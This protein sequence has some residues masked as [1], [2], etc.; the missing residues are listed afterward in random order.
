[1]K[2][3]K[4]PLKVFLGV[5]AFVVAMGICFGC[6]ALY[7]KKEIAK[8]R[9]NMPVFDPLPSATP[10]PTDKGT[11]ASYVDSLYSKLLGADDA[12]VSHS[13]GIRI[14]LDLDA[15]TFDEA[16]KDVLGLLKD[17][18]ASRISEMYESVS[19]TRVDS[20][21]ILPD[22][23]FEIADVTDAGAE[24]GRTNEKGE[25]FDD[26]YYYVTMSLDPSSRDAAAVLGSDVYADVMTQFG[27]AA[28]ISGVSAEIAG[29]DLSFKI[30][31]VGDKLLS[32]TVATRYVFTA[33]AAFKGDYVDLGSQRIGA[34]VTKTESFLFKW[35]GL[36][37]TD[38]AVAVKP[39]TL[40]TLPLEICV[41]DGATPDEW[42]LVAEISDPE[43]LE[44]E[45]V[46]AMTTLKVSEDPVTIKMT[47]RYDGHEYSDTITVFVTDLEVD[48]D[49]QTGEGE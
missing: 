21:D 15:T 4:K 23:L 49:W 11:I 3:M 8:G 20:T 19:W 1:M 48:Y 45:G 47:L 32:A 5:V 40:S 36:R 39:G 44:I 37:F 46:G 24:R 42:E 26:D 16:D 10:L 41:D 22:M 27:S 25:I 17:S 13:V 7:A 35:Y 28:D 18:W 2:K 34:G 6:L 14:D 38:R 33:D 30:D 43:V 29:I 9:F 31:R 12:E